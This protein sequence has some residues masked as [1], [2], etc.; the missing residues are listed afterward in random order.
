MST[1]ETMNIHKALSEL[2]VIGDRIT[3]GLNKMPF[4]LVNEHVNTKIQGVNISEY[5]EQMKSAYQSVVD[6][7]NRRDAIKRAVVKSNATTIV[8]IGGKEY[9]VAEAI[10]MKNHGMEYI[11]LLMGKMASEL[12][13]CKRT[14]EINNGQNLES[15][16]DGYIR[17]LFNTTDMK[18]LTVEATA[19]RDEFIKQHTTELVDPLKVSDKIAELEKEYYE[20]IADVDAVLSVS[21]ATTEIEISY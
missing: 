15:R 14:A 7:I 18:N 6:L 1:T 17:N 8:M 9:T 16:A 11:K 19:A 21:N 13:R 10:E 2:K 5:T 4:V 3:K 12:E 20:F